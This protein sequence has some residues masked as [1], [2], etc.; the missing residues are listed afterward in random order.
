MAGDDGWWRAVAGGGAWRR[1]EGR[2]VT[3]GEWV[4]GGAWWAVGG[5]W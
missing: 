1:V 2:R 4:A 3:S 5:G